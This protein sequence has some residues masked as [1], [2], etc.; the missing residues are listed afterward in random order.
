[1]IALMSSTTGWALEG[2][3]G[4]HFTLD[5]V[6]MQ[7]P[8]TAEAPVPLVARLVNRQTSVAIVRLLPGDVALRTCRRRS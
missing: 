4:S 6:I 2:S 5:L 8:G 3:L 1:M 7:T